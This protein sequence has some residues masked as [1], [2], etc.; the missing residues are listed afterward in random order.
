MAS[1][2]LFKTQKTLIVPYGLRSWLGCVCRAVLL[3][4]PENVIEFIFDYCMGLLN[5]RKNPSMDVKDLTY[6][7]Q[8]NRGKV[9]SFHFSMVC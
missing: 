2:N 5:F 6:L 3:E 1:R 9:I 7:Y 4:D 8:K